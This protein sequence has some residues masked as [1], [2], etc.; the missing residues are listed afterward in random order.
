MPKIIFDATPEQIE[1]LAP[2]DPDSPAN[3]IRQALGWPTALRGGIRPGGFEPGNRHNPRATKARKT[4]SKKAA[5][6]I[7]G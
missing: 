6:G 2:A 3:R 5:T 7:G 4:K 1:S